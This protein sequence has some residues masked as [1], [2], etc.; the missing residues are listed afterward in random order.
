[1]LLK[2]VN[3]NTEISDELDTVLLCVNRFLRIVDS[4]WIKRAEAVLGTPTPFIYQKNIL[5]SL[6]EEKYVYPSTLEDVFPLESLLNYA[7][8]NRLR[9]LISYPEFPSRC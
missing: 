2:I 5:S 4:L 3:E 8:I 9:Y 7:Y 6:D 1:M